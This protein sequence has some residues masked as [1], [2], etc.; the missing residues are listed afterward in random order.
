MSSAGTTA[1]AVTGTGT[2]EGGTARVVE[3]VTTTDVEVLV[4]VVVGNVIGG[5]ST[6]LS[7]NPRMVRIVL[8]KFIH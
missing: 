8:R 5:L 7:H 4:V 2:V 6:G 3:V 1:D